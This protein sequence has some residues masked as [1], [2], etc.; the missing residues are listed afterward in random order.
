[1]R[2]HPLDDDTLFQV[3]YQVLEPVDHHPIGPRHTATFARNW[4][5]A[6]DFV[7]KKYGL[8]AS[9]RVMINRVYAYDRSSGVKTEE[10]FYDRYPPG[11]ETPPLPAH[12]F[13]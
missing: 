11:R 7:R 12:H 13:G 4:M 3:D 9:P 1:M 10:V 2:T 5:E 8:D 6:S